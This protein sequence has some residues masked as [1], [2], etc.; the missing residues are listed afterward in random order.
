MQPGQPEEVESRNCGDAA[1]V[2]QETLAVENPNAQ[3]GIVSCESDTPDHR[4]DA[5]RLQIQAHW[6]T[7]GPP[8]GHVA[9]LDGRVDALPRDVA[10]DQVLDSL[11]DG[12]GRVQVPL[13]GWPEGEH[14]G[15]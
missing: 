15:V 3:P 13:Q 8:H 2:T 1:A 7:V 11:R 12:V 6:L 4:R 5:R 14:S 9:V 10:V